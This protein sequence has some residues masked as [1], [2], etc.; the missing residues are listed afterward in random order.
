MKNITN[1]RLV[2]NLKTI[3]VRTKMYLYPAVINYIIVIVCRYMYFGFYKYNFLNLTRII[4]LYPWKIYHDI[5]FF[6]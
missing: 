3:Q 6:L 1:N 2:F 4:F 5:V